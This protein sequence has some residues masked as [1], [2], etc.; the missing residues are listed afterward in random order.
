MAKTVLVIDDEEILTKTFARLLEKQGYQ[1]LMALR[2]DDAFAI[3]EVED[4]DLILSDIRLPGKNGIEIV[5]GIIAILAKMGKP[6]PPIIFITGF[7][8]ES[9]EKSAQA[10]APVAYLA[11][12]FDVQKL[13]K[14][15]QTQTGL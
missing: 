14:L 2:A 10:L 7:A 15:I 1:V 4:F 8:D 12:P 11:K 6:K 3:A 5:K 9:L 13:L